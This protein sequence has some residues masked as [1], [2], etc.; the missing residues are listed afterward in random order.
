MSLPSFAPFPAPPPA[1][2]SRLST[3]TVPLLTPADAVV[4]LKPTLIDF[5]TVE[6]PVVIANALKRPVTELVAAP[7]VVTE[8][9]VPSSPVLLSV[10]TWAAGTAPPTNTRPKSTFL[11]EL[12]SLFT[13]APAI[14]TW[15]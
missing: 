4:V 6:L 9:Y 1:V 14:D 10:L 8:K 7:L 15:L 12:P 5:V 2:M 13:L 3:V 11:V